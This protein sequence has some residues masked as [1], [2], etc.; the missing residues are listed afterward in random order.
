MDELIK[1][2]TAELNKSPSQK[3]IEE[4]GKHKN[5]ASSE[6]MLIDILEIELDKKTPITDRIVNIEPLNI[7]WSG[8]SEESSNPIF[9][10]RIRQIAFNSDTQQIPQ[11][12]KA[13]RAIDESLKTQSQLSTHGPSSLSNIFLSLEILKA[14][15]KVCSQEQ[16]T[17]I[18][19]VISKLNKTFEHKYSKAG[20]WAKTEV[21]LIRKLSEMRIKYALPELYD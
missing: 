18:E 11:L 20:P 19:N 4:L 15:Q 14:I 3:L 7:I 9:Y 1:E 8:A 12:I 21:P 2:H 5:T 16:S 10:N 17:T 13:V 6:Q